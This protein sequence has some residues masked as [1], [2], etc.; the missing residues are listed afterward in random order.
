TAAPAL[1]GLSLDIP[2]GTLV[3]VTGPVGSGKSSLARAIVGVC[4]IESGAI[5][6]DGM[7]VIDLPLGKRRTMIGYLPQDAGLFP[8]S[9]GQNVAFDPADGGR[10]DAALRRAIRV[11]ALEDDVSDFGRGLD[12]QI[13]EGGIR[14]SGGQRQRIGLA[15]AIATAAPHAPGLLVLDDPFSAVDVT[16]EAA[17]IGSLRHALGADAPPQRQAT[18]AP[19][20]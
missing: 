10:D 12:T 8:C 1:Q 4:P 7:P 11:A 6:I 18:L 3:A 5:L 15:R 20:S 13:G 17:I 9:L 19:F 14:V 2:A 16:T